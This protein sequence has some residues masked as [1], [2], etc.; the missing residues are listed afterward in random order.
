MDLKWFDYRLPSTNVLFLQSFMLA[1]LLALSVVNNSLLHFTSIYSK[2]FYQYLLT[3]PLCPA[4]LTLHNF[5]FAVSNKQSVSKYQ[6]PTIIL[7]FS[8]AA[9]TGLALLLIT[10]AVT[11]SAAVAVPFGCYSPGSGAQKSPVESS[12]GKL[13]Q[14][15]DTVYRFWL[16]EWSKYENFAQFTSR[17]STSMFHGGGLSDILGA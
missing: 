1:S 17:F 5:L 6:I 3:A 13:K 12:L 16:Q 10:A 11:Y 14:F 7:L 8:L 2:M 9:N 15:V 4:A